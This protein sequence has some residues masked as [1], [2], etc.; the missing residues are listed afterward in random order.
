MLR[1]LSCY[2]VTVATRQTFLTTETRNF[3]VI[4]S[5]YLYFIRGLKYLISINGQEYENVFKKWLL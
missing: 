2:D 3:R 5:L 1:Q 4:L